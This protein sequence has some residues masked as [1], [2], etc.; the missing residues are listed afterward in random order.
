[1]SSGLRGQEVWLA[2]LRGFKIVAKWR[3]KLSKY[4][5]HLARLWSLCKYNF[6]E[7]SR[8]LKIFQILPA[9]IDQ[10][11]THHA[12]FLEAIL[13]LRNWLP[14]LTLYNNGWTK[15]GWNYAKELWKWA[16]KALLFQRNDITSDHSVSRLS[17][18]ELDYAED[19]TRWTQQWTAP[20]DPLMLLSF[21]EYRSS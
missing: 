15:V 18:T 7:S 9:W 2:C 11:A 5:V 14:M 12:M 8:S 19:V 10:N 3:A 20:A 17:D 16:W 21:L 13:M 4:M 1:M 6:Q